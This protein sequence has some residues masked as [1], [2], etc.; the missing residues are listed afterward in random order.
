MIWI[1]CGQMRKEQSSPMRIS[2]EWRMYEVRLVLR[3]VRTFK[4]K[5]ISNE[6]GGEAR[7]G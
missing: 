6:H 3:G 2:Y 1:R 5:V 7:K 4:W